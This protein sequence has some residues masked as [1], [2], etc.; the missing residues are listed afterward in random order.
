MAKTNIEL[1]VLQRQLTDLRLR[2]GNLDGRVNQIARDIRVLLTMA[3]NH[4]EAMKDLNHQLGE[5]IG[6]FSG[7]FSTIEER[8]D[9]Q[10]Q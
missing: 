1:G 3:Q 2:F 8:L 5:I 10:E 7:R 9:R 4:D 6:V